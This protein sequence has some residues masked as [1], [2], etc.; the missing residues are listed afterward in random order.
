VPSN[1]KRKERQ[2]LK[3]DEKK[4]AQRKAQSVSPYKRIGQFGQVEACY[5]NSDWK[6]Q[7]L[8]SVYVIHRN[9]SGGH[10]IATFL[11]DVWCAGLK[12][13]WGRIDFTQEDID[14]ALKRAR[15]NF[16]IQRIDIDTARK[17][18]V[19]GIRFSR[20]NG[21]RLPERGAQC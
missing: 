7:G 12:D 20:Q 1:A 10:A 14:R 3:R 15:D 4:A 18:I 16:D 6:Q 9:P 21:F 13:A 17:L 2:R 5:V 11:I 8:A 19:G